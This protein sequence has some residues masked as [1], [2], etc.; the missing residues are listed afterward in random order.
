MVKR[1][2]VIAVVMVLSGAAAQATWEYGVLEWNELD[3]LQCLWVTESEGISEDTCTQL[4]LTLTGDFTD[5]I[6]VAFSR[7]LNYLGDQ[8]WEMVSAV[9]PASQMDYVQYLFKRPAQ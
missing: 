6:V 9:K 2:L 1:L 5:N 3:T 7:T 4:Y 8:G